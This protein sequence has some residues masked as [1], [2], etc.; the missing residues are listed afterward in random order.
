M[1]AIDSVL[2]AERGPHLQHRVGETKLKDSWRQ[3]VDEPIE[4]IKSRHVVDI[5]F[6]SNEC[7][8]L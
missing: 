4:R 8:S 2:I 3:K 1:S 5:T 7:A 6:L